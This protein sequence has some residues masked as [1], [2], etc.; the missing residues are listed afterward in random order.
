MVAVAFGGY[1]NKLEFLL[2]VDRYIVTISM[3]DTRREFCIVIIV[4]GLFSIMLLWV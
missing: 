4:D 1:A 2:R 3:G